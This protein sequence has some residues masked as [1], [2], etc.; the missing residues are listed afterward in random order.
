[1]VCL[2]VVETSPDIRDDSNCEQFGNE[3]PAVAPAAADPPGAAPSV[4]RA[5]RAWH[6]K[7][8]VLAAAGTLVLL[9]AALISMLMTTGT[10]SEG[11]TSGPPLSGSTT[12]AGT[13]T[14]TVTV[15]RYT[16]V[17]YTTYTTTTYSTTTTYTTTSTVYVKRPRAT[18]TSSAATPGGS[19][20][21]PM[22]V[23]CAPADVVSGVTD[24]DVVVR[25]CGMQRP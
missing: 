15:T 3:H 16:T 1:M 24:D 12:A 5:T 19:T 2:D 17:T 14:T 4:P 11:D 9:A 18:A 10:P 22:A 25:V 8:A 6:R 13:Y 23:Q 20:T 21:I 7:A